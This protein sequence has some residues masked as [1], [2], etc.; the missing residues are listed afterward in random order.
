[1]KCHGQLPLP[2]NQSR[3][4]QI[5]NISAADQ[6]NERRSSNEEPHW[7]VELADQPVL[8]RAGHQ[9][10]AIVASRIHPPQTFSDRSEVVASIFGCGSGFEMSYAP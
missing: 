6:Q 1:M 2:T 4:Q 8:Q 10:E 3:Q 7:I 9:G 5:G